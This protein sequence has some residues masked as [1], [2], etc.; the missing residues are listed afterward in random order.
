MIYK[1]KK[2]IKIDSP[3][4]ENLNEVLDQVKIWEYQCDSPLDRSLLRCFVKGR[5]TYMVLMQLNFLED[6]EVDCC[7][8]SPGERLEIFL[9]KY[10]KSSI[11]LDSLNLS[12]ITEKRK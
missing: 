9:N 10:K 5:E 3:V 12:W 11:V 7:K 4:K 8:E 2:I 6:I 1:T